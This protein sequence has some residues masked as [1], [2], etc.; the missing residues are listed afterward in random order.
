M[1]E[2]QYSVLGTEEGTGC[3]RLNLFTIRV[4]AHNSAGW[5]LEYVDKL[6]ASACV[7]VANLGVLHTATGSAVTA[8][9]LLGR[10]CCCCS[11]CGLRGPRDLLDNGGDAAATCV[12]LL[13]CCLGHMKACELLFCLLS[14]V[15]T[16]TNPPLPLLP[17]PSPSPFL[18]VRA[19]IVA[20][21][22]TPTDVC[23]AVA[24]FFFLTQLRPVD[25]DG[26]VV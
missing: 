6:V 15:P 14:A 20:G 16:P 12:F 2:Y 17:F 1:Y 26:L 11:W 21:C 23:I 9:I 4:M 18:C 25:H 13:F 7:C 24:S 3:C 10:R 5:C 8:S 19:F 22:H